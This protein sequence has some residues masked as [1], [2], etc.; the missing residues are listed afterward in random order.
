[1]IN[2]SSKEQIKQLFLLAIPVSIGQAG[3]ILANMADAAML[4]K[5]N[6][7]HMIAATLGF[8]VFIIPFILLIGISI[9]MTTLVAQNDG[10]GKKSNIL[11]SALFTYT[12]IGIVIASIIYSS[13]H[14]L[15]YLH[16]DPLVRELSKPYIRLMAISIIPISIF[17]SLKQYF[18]GY[19][20]TI[21]AT[22]SSLIA[23]VLNIFFNYLLIFGNWGFESMGIEGAGYA[24]LLA[25]VLSIPIF[26]ACIV[27]FKKY[28][29]KIS[30]SEFKIY[31][32]KCLELVKIGLPIGFQMFIEVTAFTVAGIFIGWISNEALGAHNIALQY[33]GL[34][35]LLV[36]GIGSAATVMAGNYF[37]ER[38]R[39]MLHQLIKNVLLL[40]IFYEV[41]TA[42][43][44]W[45][46]SSEMPYLFL[47]EKDIGIVTIAITLIKSAAIFQI[48]DG[49]QN[50][51]QGI[52][53][54]VQDFQFPMWIGAGAHYTFTLGGGY[55]LAF[56]LGLGVQGMW[57]GF[58]MGLSIIAIL[59]YLRLKFVLR[60]LDGKFFDN[61]IE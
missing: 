44:F 12:S 7:L 53:R 10:E 2:L 4:G 57:M 3:N 61:L 21:L 26:L 6:S 25:R 15:D 5:Y 45:L 33:A 39:K 32:R 46:M 47:Q 58:V 16:P 22:I 43:F 19:S 41:T 48:P 50:T 40:A 27:S 55:I 8:E 13:I 51:L 34:T 37:G 18:E 11:G 36:T 30:K 9:G 49:I 59:L 24:T 35:Y 29:D 17:L 56:P 14:F 42:C 38:N 20:L 31:K 60:R 52:L 23:N 54:G 28:K 1:M